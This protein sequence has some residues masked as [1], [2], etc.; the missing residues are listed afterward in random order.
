M[1][2]RSKGQS[3]EKTDYAWMANEDL[4]PAPRE[5]PWKLE[6]GQALPFFPDW[7]DLRL[8]KQQPDESAMAHN[9]RFG[10]RGESFWIE[11]QDEERG[12]WLNFPL[13]GP[14]CFMGKDGST[15]RRDH[16]ATGERRQ[17]IFWSAR[18]PSAFASFPGGWF[19]DDGWSL[20]RG[21]HEL[22]G[23]EVQ[24]Q[25]IDLSFHLPQVVDLHVANKCQATIQP[26]VKGGVFTGWVVGGSNGWMLRVYR[27]DL[28]DQEDHCETRF[29]G[30]KQALPWRVELQLRAEWL[31][32]KAT[33]LVHLADRSKAWSLVLYALDVWGITLF[34]IDSTGQKV[35]IKL[36]G[37]PGGW[38]ATRQ[39]IHTARSAL[40]A[41]ARGCYLAAIL[42]GV[43]IYYLPS[44]N[45][46]REW[47]EELAPGFQE[48]L[49]AIESEIEAT[50][51]FH[52]ERNGP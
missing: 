24:V 40:Y 20:I 3:V 32:G 39:P 13:V 8:T 2:T 33:S 6:P 29:P 27:K 51:E 14:V 22:P 10:I 30:L 49:A 44:A 31:K 42:A 47:A 1:A 19:M 23:F 21:Y 37:E 11:P 26:F 34:E 45:I 43:G 36:P 48:R 5:T 7:L 41:Q 16:R 15:R 52:R 28:H 18:N 17:A 12:L 50:L 25:R 46:R 38:N 4:T 35:P 9:S